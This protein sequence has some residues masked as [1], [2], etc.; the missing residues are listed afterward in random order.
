M[1]EKEDILNCASGATPCR[2]PI[3]HYIDKKSTEKQL[4]STLHVGVH[5]KKYL[6]SYSDRTYYLIHKNTLF[7]PEQIR[8]HYNWVKSIY[9]EKVKNNPEIEKIFGPPDE[10]S[11]ELDPKDYKS[12]INSEENYELGFSNKEFTLDLPKLREDIKNTILND[13]HITLQTNTRVTNIKPTVAGYELDIQPKD[14]KARTIKADFVINA[15]WHNIP[16]LSKSID[17]AKKLDKFS[18][19]LKRMIEVDV[20]AILDEKKKNSVFVG[21][22]PFTAITYIDKNTAYLTYEPKTNVAKTYGSEIDE[23]MKILLKGNLSEE[24]AKEAAQQIIDGAKKY[25]NLEG[26]KFDPK[27]HKI[28]HGIVI[29]SGDNNNLD[30]PNSDIHKR[31]ED[32]IKEKF[33]DYLENY[34]F[35]L[36]YG[37]TNGEKVVSIIKKKSIIKPIIDRLACSSIEQSSNTNNNEDTINFKRIITQTMNNKERMLSELVSIRKNPTSFFSNSKINS[38][39]KEENLSANYSLQI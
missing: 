6:R 30:D 12:L 26:I 38:I 37:F 5:Y 28:K 4:D 16:M 17:P 39:K 14:G 13:K 1:E 25:L 24:E 7:S 20:S 32:G 18:F 22:G 15:A 2:V 3:S 36:I 9:K 21:I 33:Y 19:R 27:K 8:N 31:S 35:K 23:A 11:I 34:A 10:L 29:T